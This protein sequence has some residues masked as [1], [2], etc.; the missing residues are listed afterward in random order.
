MKLVILQVTFVFN[1][2]KK[3]IGFYDYYYKNISDSMKG[4]KEKIFFLVPKEN[5]EPVTVPTIKPTAKRG[6]KKKN[7]DG[8]NQTPAPKVTRGRKKKNQLDDIQQL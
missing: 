7:P 8:D 5:Q 2:Y 3:A 6:R 1:Y 4:L